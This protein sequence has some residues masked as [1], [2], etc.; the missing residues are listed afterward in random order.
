MV[1]ALGLHL[2]TIN[3]KEKVSLWGDYKC[4]ITGQLIGGSNGISPESNLGI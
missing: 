2:R 4:S 3:I 1:L